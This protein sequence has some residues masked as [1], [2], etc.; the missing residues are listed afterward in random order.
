MWAF[1]SADLIPKLALS[2]LSSRKPFL[3]LVCS[4]VFQTLAVGFDHAIYDEAL[5]SHHRNANITIH[6]RIQHHGFQDISI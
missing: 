4:A 6:S 3:L 1:S 2:F 5:R